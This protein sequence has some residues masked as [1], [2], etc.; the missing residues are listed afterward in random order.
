MKNISK[1]VLSS[2]FDGEYDALWSAYHIVINLQGFELSIETTVGVRGIN[3]PVRVKINDGK[4]YI[5]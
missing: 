4:L 2:K 1:E 3:C 5:L